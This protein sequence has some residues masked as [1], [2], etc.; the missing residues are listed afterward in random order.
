MAAAAEMEIER[1]EVLWV[2]G[3]QGGASTG[4]ALAEFSNQQFIRVAAN[5]APA[6]GP[7]TVS[8]AA[9]TPDTI[10]KFVTGDRMLFQVTPLATPSSG[11]PLS[12]TSDSV[13]LLLRYRQ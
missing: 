13:E 10:V 11:A 3:A 8:F 4:V 1:V 12:L 5:T 6:V 7:A 2:A 9:T